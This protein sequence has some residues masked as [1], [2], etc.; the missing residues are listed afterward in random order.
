MADHEAGNAQETRPS[1]T[2]RRLVLASAS[3]QRRALLEEAGY[4]FEVMP[5][6]NEQGEITDD[7]CELAERLAYFK[8]RPVAERLAEGLV[9]GADTICVIGR[10]VVGKPADDQDARRILRTLAGTRHRVITGVCLIDAASGLRLT[11]SEVTWVTMRP[12][13]DQ[14]VEDYVASGAGRGKAGAYAVRA[15]H[16][17]Y[18]ERIEGSISNVLGLP[19]ELFE[20]MLRAIKHL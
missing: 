4:R 17:P 1:R 14:E 18:V 5:P 12:M 11:G 10:Q 7:P 13:S 19:M 2:A 8:A 6:G 15:D 3:P 20:R 16:D 9:L